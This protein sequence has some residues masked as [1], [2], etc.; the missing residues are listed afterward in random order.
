KNTSIKH[1]HHF[2]YQVIWYHNLKVVK[3]LP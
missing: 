2:N 3:F 1:T